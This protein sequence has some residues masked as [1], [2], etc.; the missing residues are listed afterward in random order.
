MPTRRRRFSC[1]NILM[2]CDSFV[3]PA[4]FV[5]DADQLSMPPFWTGGAECMLNGCAINAFSPAML[6]NKSASYP[7]TSPSAAY[8]ASKVGAASARA[9]SAPLARIA[10]S[11]PRSSR[12]VR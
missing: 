7:R 10:S 9:F 8:V 11:A 12:S 2:C 5:P 4:A 1:E 6:R 3:R